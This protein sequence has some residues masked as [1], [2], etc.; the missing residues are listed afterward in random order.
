M[1]ALLRKTCVISS[2]Y[3]D[4]GSS[5]LSLILSI[6]YGWDPITDIHEPLIEEIKEN[7]DKL[8][9]AALPGSYLIDL[10]PFLIHVPYWLSKWKQEGAFYYERNTALVEGIIDEVRKKRAEVCI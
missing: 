6:L 5:P 2:S 7:I 8:A 3:D 4:T 9:N 1:S 10:F